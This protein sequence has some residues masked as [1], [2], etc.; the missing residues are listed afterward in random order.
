MGGMLRIE[1]PLLGPPLMV[2]R[3]G[4][5]A[6]ACGCATARSGRCLG[7]G[8]LFVITFWASRAGAEGWE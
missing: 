6:T 4:A 3:D 8:I 5:I 1:L 2:G 7:M